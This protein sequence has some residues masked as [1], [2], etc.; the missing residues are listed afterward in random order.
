MFPPCNRSWPVPARGRYRDDSSAKSS[1][2]GACL[3]EPVFALAASWS[4]QHRGAHRLGDEVGDRDVP[5]HLADRHD[6]RLLAGVE[7]DD[8][9]GSVVAELG[10]N[11][12]VAGLKPSLASATRSSFSACRC[13]SVSR[14]LSRFSGAF[15]LGLCAQGGLTRLPRH[16]CEAFEGSPT[17]GVPGL[18]L[19]IDTSLRG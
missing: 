16:L 7:L 1:R 19:A 17:R 18:D 2:R 6:G 10:D 4:P 8:S 11:H 9:A 12:A 3:C 14:W 15:C 5:L 13:R